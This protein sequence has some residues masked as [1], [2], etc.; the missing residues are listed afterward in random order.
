MQV[1]KRIIGTQRK[2]CLLCVI[3]CSN[4]CSMTSRVGIQEQFHADKGN[5]SWALMEAL[6]L[7]RCRK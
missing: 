3:K 7:H 6:L 1:I 2:E 5:V 4:A